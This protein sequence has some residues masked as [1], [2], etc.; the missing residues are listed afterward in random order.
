MT[1]QPS[2]PSGLDDAGPANGVSR[3][4]REAIEWVV[5]M[6]SGEVTD[7]DRAAFAAWRSRGAAQEAALA[8][9]RK[10][11][12][13]LGPA[14]PARAK[15]PARPQRP[16]LALAASLLVVAGLGVQALHS[17]RE[18][19]RRGSVALGDADHSASGSRMAVEAG[20]AEGRCRLV[21][22]RGEASFDVTPNPN[23]LA[24]GDAGET[25]VRVLDT[26][27][28][29]KPEAADVLVTITGGRVEVNDGRVARILT[30]GE[31]LRCRADRHQADIDPG[32]AAGGLTAYAAPASPG[33]AG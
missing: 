23:Q 25:Q 17:W 26:A 18:D 11:W 10:L 8:A 14:L 3:T 4:E 24:A 16:L 30:A 31:Q 20:D 12:I 29:L 6:T 21:L 28:S 19:G 2:D 7:E 9:A 32:A 33:R 22:G 27:F 13:G 15:V 5:R 1:Q